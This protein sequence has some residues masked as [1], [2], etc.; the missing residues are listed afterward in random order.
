LIHSSAFPLINQSS[1]PLSSLLAILFLTPTPQK[2]SSIFLQ[3]PLFMFLNDRAV[4]SPPF[5]PTKPLVEHKIGLLTVS[6]FVSYGSKLGNI[7]QHGGGTP[8]YCPAADFPSPLKS[9]F[10]LPLLSFPLDQEPFSYMGGLAL[11]PP[12]TKSP[13]L[14]HMFPSPPRNL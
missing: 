9:R 7:H 6:S 5:F 8:Y 11:F 12:V 1:L 13:F 2:V 14:L 4:P 3:A 10:G